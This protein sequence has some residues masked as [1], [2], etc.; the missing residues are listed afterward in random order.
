MAEIRLAARSLARSPGFTTVAI[1]TLALGIGAN[2]AVFS[3]LNAVL[4]R[5]LPYADPSR[6]VLI[7]ESAPFFGVQDSP[8]SPANYADWKVR[9]RSFEQMGALEINGYR[10]SGD[11][12]PDLVLGAVVTAGLFRALGTQPLLGR[13]FRDDD[14]RLDAA[15]VAIIGE[16]L[17]RRRFAADPAIIGK[18]IRLGAEKHTVVGVLANGTE[19]PSQYVHKLG[20]VWTPL[21]ATYTPRQWNQRIIQHPKKDQTWTAQAVEPVQHAA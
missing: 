5:P 16:A 7:W 6:L 19:P 4:L 17:W 2:T 18:P 9:A 11:G 15:K 21:G 12:Q 13:V 14:D 20:E 10:L 1:L 8:V 3:L